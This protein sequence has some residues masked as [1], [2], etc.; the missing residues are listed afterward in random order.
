MVKHLRKHLRKH[1]PKK[2]HPIHTLSLFAI[3]AGV[4]FGAFLA[5]Q[6]TIETEAAG[7]CPLRCQRSHTTGPDATKCT[8]P[9]TKEEITKKHKEYQKK[10]N[11]ADP[12]EKAEAQKIKGE[13]KECAEKLDACIAGG[14]TFDKGPARNTCD[15][16]PGKGLP[17]GTGEK[18]KGEEKP[19][20]GEGGA[21]KMPEIPKIPP[22]EPKKEEPKQPCESQTAPSLECP[23]KEEKNIFERAEDKLKEFLGIDNPDADI[24]KK[25]EGVATVIPD[26]NGGNTNDA[27]ADTGAKD[28]T[29]TYKD[30][31]AAPEDSNP[32]YDRYNASILEQAANAQS[33]EARQR[34]L[35]NQMGRDTFSRLDPEYQRAVADASET[36]TNNQGLGFVQSFIRWFGNLFSF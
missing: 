23:P 36:R 35:Q 11:S 15:T 5:M 22:K 1:L 28:D 3:I 8:P 17:K 31:Q 24:Y 32:L 4:G 27:T 7:T 29:V 14:A 12:K 13:I 25:E 33:E 21:P 2:M 10:K 18:P 30:G 20:G 19:K 9:G 16:D 6:P 34:I 26:Q